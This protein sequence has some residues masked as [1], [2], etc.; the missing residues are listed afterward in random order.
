MECAPP[1]GYEEVRDEQRELR[2]RRERGEEP[3]VPERALADVARL[4]AVVEDLPARFEGVSNFP[5]SWRCRDLGMWTETPSL[6][7]QP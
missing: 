5:W 7:T 4:D 1:R 3:A 2:Q 6:A